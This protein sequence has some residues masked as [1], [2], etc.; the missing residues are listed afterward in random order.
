MHHYDPEKFDQLTLGLSDWL[1]SADLVP[2]LKTLAS[3]FSADKAA[4]LTMISPIAEATAGSYIGWDQPEVDR[5]FN[6]Y[7][8]LDNVA[9]ALVNCVDGE[10]YTYAQILGPKQFSQSV[11][12][13]EHWIPAGCGYILTTPITLD[14]STR[15]SLSLGRPLGVDYSL[16]DRALLAAVARHVRSLL[17]VHRL[18]EQNR[19]IESAL[20]GAVGQFSA[21]LFLLT[22]DRKIVFVN[23]EGLKLTG[24]LRLFDFERDRTLTPTHRRSVENLQRAIDCVSGRQRPQAVVR[25]KSDSQSTDYTALVVRLTNTFSDPLALSISSPLV[26]LFVSANASTPRALSCDVIQESLGVTSR[27]AHVVKLLLD[28]LKIAEI[29]KVLEITPDGVR[30][31]LKQLYQKTGTHRQIELIQYVVS[32]TR[33]IQM[34]AP[35]PTVS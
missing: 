17:P 30:Y 26:A 8:Y 29:S 13:N 32:A 1:L 9:P 6:H 27:E 34:N 7:C 12:V 16:E 11:I 25:L 15:F 31:H 10:T 4:L 20:K 3:A 5:Y 19:M 21:P 23:E 18:F 28:G 14:R 22:H 2:W 35:S 24:P 33:V